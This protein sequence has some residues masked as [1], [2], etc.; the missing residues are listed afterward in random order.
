ML[1]GQAH[2]QNVPE[3]FEGL[4]RPHVASFDYFIGD[5]MH[6]VVENCDPIEV[7]SLAKDET[8][9]LLALLRQYGQARLMSLERRLFE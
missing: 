2:G 8:S 7:S 6:A 9:D 3:E 1:K 4:V 5:G